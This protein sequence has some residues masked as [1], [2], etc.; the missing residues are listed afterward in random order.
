MYKII[1]SNTKDYIPV[2]NL[3]EVRKILF[4]IN[5]GD[6]VIICSNGIFNPSYLVAILY[7]KRGVEDKIY[8]ESIG[9]RNEQ[10]SKFIKLVI[11]KTK[12]LSDKKK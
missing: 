8:L 7:D 4:R 12:M 9:Y 6:N 10:A 1:L 5:E 3:E 2:A 11:P